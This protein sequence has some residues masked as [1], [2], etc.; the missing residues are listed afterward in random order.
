MQFLCMRVL[1]PYL[2]NNITRSIK[3]KFIINNVIIVLLCTTKSTLV[4]S[5]RFFRNFID[6]IYLHG[7]ND[8][9]DSGVLSA[10]K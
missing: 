8:K 6:K 1:L 3:T 2:I 5:N 10:G 4:N 9:D 7:H